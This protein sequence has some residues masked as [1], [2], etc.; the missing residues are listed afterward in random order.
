MGLHLTLA[1]LVDIPQWGSPVTGVWIVARWCLSG[2]SGW[3][4][5]YYPGLLAAPVLVDEE[6]CGKVSAD[7]SALPSD[8]TCSGFPGSGSDIGHLKF[9]FSPCKGLARIDVVSWT[10]P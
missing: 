6:L 5:W 9:S 8:S 4:E 2:Y 1:A 7:Q 3:E 10:F